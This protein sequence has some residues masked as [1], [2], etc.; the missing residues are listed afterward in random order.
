VFFADFDLMLE[1][2]DK[3]GA[4]DGDLMADND[5]KTLQVLRSFGV[6]GARNGDYSTAT[7]RLVFD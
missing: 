6:S 5:R 2:A 7:V 3:A 4:A 1:F